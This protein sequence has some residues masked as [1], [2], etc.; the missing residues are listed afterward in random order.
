MPVV[1]SIVEAAADVDLLAGDPEHA[2]LLL[3]IAAALRGVRSQPGSDVRRTAERLRGALGTDRYDAAYD[4][5]A[6]M[7]RDDAMAEIRKIFSSS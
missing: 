6:T 3:G 2:A 1:S 5:G 4:Q 7:N